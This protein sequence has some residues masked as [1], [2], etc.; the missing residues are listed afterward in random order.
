[1]TFATIF[2]TKC[3]KQCFDINMYIKTF[4]TLN[5]LVFFYIYSL[6]NFAM[7]AIQFWEMSISNVK[8]CYNKMAS[9]Y[10]IHF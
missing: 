7:S 9:A 2:L 3:Y 1:M 4:H 10:I 5:T 8:T 6:Y